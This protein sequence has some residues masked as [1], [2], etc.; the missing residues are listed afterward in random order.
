MIMVLHKKIKTTDS[1]TLYAS[2][3][4]EV[5]MVIDPRAMAHIIQRL[6]N[7]YS[8]PIEA[9]V[10]ELV[11]NAIDTTNRI[12]EAD[13]KPIQITMPTALNGEFIV[14]DFGQGMSAED[15]KT[16]YAQY[17][18][19]TKEDD[20]N[21]VG[22]YGLGAKAPL[23]YCSQFVVES[24]KDGFATTA[25]L[26]SEGINNVVRVLDPEPTNKRNGTKVI[27]P[28]Q[29]NDTSRFEQAI[30][31]YKKFSFGIDLDFIGAESDLGVDSS[32]LIKIGQA[33]VEDYSDGTPVMVDIY[34]NEIEYGKL[35]YKYV[36]GEMS[37]D[38][39]LILSGW[40]YAN[41]AHKSTNAGFYVDLVP[42][43]VDFDSSRDEI[44]LNSRSQQLHQKVSMK[45]KS[46]IEEAIIA[47][48]A[49]F[50]KDEILDSI[51]KIYKGNQYSNK[52]KN[53]D[54]LGKLVDKDG[55]PYVK[56]L[57]KTSDVDYFLALGRN[58]YS[59]KNLVIKTSNIQYNDKVKSHRL[60]EENIA[61][62]RALIDS[63]FAMNDNNRFYS[64]NSL[65]FLAPELQ[66][67]VILI[68]DC[69]DAKDVKYIVSKMAMIKTDFAPT[70]AFTLF[71]TPHDTDKA[72]K[73]FSPF[74]SNP[75]TLT[76]D[77]LRDLNKGASTVTQAADGTRT[78][79]KKPK[80]K[81]TAIKAIKKTFTSPVDKFDL[82]IEA[83]YRG[84]EFI[85]IDKLNK[86]SH[87]ILLVKNSLTGQSELTTADLQ[88]LLFLAFEEN[89]TIKEV[90]FFFVGASA[91]TGG[92]AKELIAVTD[93]L[94]YDGH[95]PSFNA[96]VKEEF[97]AIS[98]TIVPSE[99][100][101]QADNPIAVAK[102]LYDDPS[103]SIMKELKSMFESLPASFEFTPEL[104]KAKAHYDE[105]FNNFSKRRTIESLKLKVEG[106]LS[107]PLMSN[108]KEVKKTLIENKTL[109]ARLEYSKWDLTEPI[110]RQIIETLLSPIMKKPSN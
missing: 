53:V 13:R 60:G 56:A 31:S 109:F 84:G 26:S 39:D 25:L 78:I 3:G 104:E 94:V 87:K 107:G 65:Y 79:A 23:S 71:A 27:I 45:I 21:Q 93:Q 63:K 36:N 110:Q 6:T 86:D 22:S 58:V 61:D 41:P 54:I 19:S 38:T 73:V 59:N 29:S 4:D 17:G 14:E 80:P 88:R 72:K 1:K 77:E 99:I 34:S 15:L 33:H 57:E 5:A 82:A 67:K 89:P 75:L 20:M 62:I 98:P 44:T 66:H 30:K 102:A 52:S 12:P 76:I 90:E 48:S 92:N 32:Q 11:S 55:V 108:V 70:T 24:V 68:T 97:K 100:I 35:L 9:T 101:I 46:I 37:F 40:R 83:I 16:I 43:L 96:T 50:N 106:D 69:V 18:V 74:V 47:E 2:G 81:E 28:V 91:F 10:R 51:V 7:L 105:N 8:N 103:V 42:G 85:E 64:A 95:I 49:N